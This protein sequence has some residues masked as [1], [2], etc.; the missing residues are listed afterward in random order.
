MPLVNFSNVDFDEIKQ[1]IKDYLRSN[2]NFTD[3]DFEGSNLSTIIDT[4]AYNTYISSYNAN[5]VSNEVFLDSATLR[6]NVVSIAR[7]I[8][9]LPR[10]RK[11]SKANVSFTVD[12]SDS[13]VVSMTLKAGPVVLSGSNFN[14]QSFTFCIMEDVTVT[15]DSDGIAT[16]DNVDVCEGSYLNS[17]FT[18][19]SSLP[20]QR[21][22][23]P[24]SGI[25]TSNLNVI[26]R[27]SAGNSVTRKYTRYDNLV[28]VDGDTPLYFLRE[29]EGET[30]ELL[31][32]DDLFGKQLE[33]A[34][35]VEVNY[36]SC[37]GSVSNGISNFTY[38]GTLQDQ[39]GASVTSGISGVTVNQISSGGEEIE[40]VESIKK[41]APNI[42]AS[43]N[44]AVTSTDFES[45]IPRIYPEAE[46]VSA[47]GGEESDPPQYGKVFISIKPSNGVFL[48][49]EIKR[50]IQL[51]L[52]KYS[53]A[54]IV[55]EIIDLK[56][57]Y[58]E[59]DT[60][61]YYNSNLTPGSSQVTTSVTNNIVNYANSTQLNKFGARFKYSKFIKVI[62]DSSEFITSNITVIHMRRDLSPLQNQFVEYNIGFGNEIHIKN[63]IGF[64]IKTS[65][66]TVSG[67]SGTVYMGDSPNADLRTGT[68]FLFRLASPT[69]P[70]I[71]KRNIG[72]IDYKKGLISLNP[73]NVLSTEVVRGTPLIEIS[74][75]PHSNDVIGLQD[76][77]LQLDTSKVNVTPIPDSISSGSDTSGGTYTVSSS[78]SNGSLVRGKGGHGGYS[79]TE[80]TTTN[81]TVSRLTTSSVSTTTSTTT[82][83]GSS[84][85]SY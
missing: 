83:S 74:A 14:R 31:F 75:C 57:L 71:V 58:I 76:L 2:S 30:Y 3:Y 39:N 10:S 48:S 1:S 82:S 36:L 59:V 55:S 7:N 29:S 25:D 43:Q 77:F 5:M 23:L 72:T 13:N 73:L 78:F 44:R 33:D 17:V 24:N 46:S 65:G 4:L 81:Q 38:I 52:R 11:S 8:G 67:I 66:F 84:G 62:D 35:Q 28:G 32:G 51:E 37:S 16:F 40:S 9:Y 56:Y 22:I 19:D 69:E 21:F 68:I 61:V 6:E 49:E 47:F 70:V 50:N 80:T 63:Q 85:S 18:V 79:S 15:V 64:N 42:Y 41:Y 54:G 60:N 12:A 53:V 27:K 20:N 45:L 34:N 26:V